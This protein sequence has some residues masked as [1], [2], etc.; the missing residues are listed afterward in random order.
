M[1]TLPLPPTLSL[2]ITSMCSSRCHHC[3]LVEGNLLNKA[4]LPMKQIIDVLDDAA[5]NGVFMVVLSGGD[6]VLHSNFSEILKAIEI[7]SML[8]LPGISGN[9][10]EAN[11]LSGL[12][13]ANV[14]CVQVSLDAALPAVH[15]HYRGAGHFDAI[16]RNVATL[17]DSGIHTNLAICIRRENRD[18]LLPL[19]ALAG[20]WGISQRTHCGRHPRKRL[21]TKPANDGRICGHWT[22]S[23]HG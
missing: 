19:V 2:N 10:L 8:P 6:P 3:Y 5:A 9:I 21:Q 7:R 23:V 18:Q 4:T 15:D 1:D 11:H 16:K 20:N 14:P 12:K 13:D 22:N 17:R